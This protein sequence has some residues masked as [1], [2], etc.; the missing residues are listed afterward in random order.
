[1]KIISIFSGKDCLAHVN[2]GNALNIEMISVGYPPYRYFRVSFNDGH[3]RELYN[4]T[5]AVF[6]EEV[7]IQIILPSL[8]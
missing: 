8:N 5:E 4:I 7:P 6:A 3:V 2:Q 1:M